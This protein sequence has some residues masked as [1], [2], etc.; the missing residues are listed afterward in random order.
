MFC[1]LAYALTD[2]CCRYSAL[3]FIPD[4]LEPAK[5]TQKPVNKD[6]K[7]GTK[8]KFEATVKGQ[9][10]PEV[11]WFRNEIKIE[12]TDRIKMDKKQVCASNTFCRN[13]DKS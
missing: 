6:V 10:A 1:P 9:P 5:I 2:L 8:V 11:E 13:F 12:P 3:F 4:K 7:E